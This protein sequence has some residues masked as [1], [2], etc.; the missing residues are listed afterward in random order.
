MGAENAKIE[1]AETD[2]HQCSTRSVYHVRHY[3]FVQSWI[4]GFVRYFSTDCGVDIFS[5]LRCIS[6]I[7][8]NQHMAVWQFSFLEF[9]EMYPGSGKSKHFTLFNV[10][11]QLSFFL[12]E[13]SGNYIWPIGCCLISGD[14]VCYFLPLG[15]AG[16]CQEES[17]LPY[18]P[19]MA[20]AS[21]YAWFIALALPMKLEGRIDIREL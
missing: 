7:D 16:K 2:G 19:Q 21:W 12:V 4:G 8:P 3:Y 9:N 1:S 15:I 17:N 18:F 5:W 10:V 14:V 11:S 13:Y 6:F 20:I